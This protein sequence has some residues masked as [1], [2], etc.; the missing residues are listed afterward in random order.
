MKAADATAKVIMALGKNNPELSG[1]G[2]EATRSS[3]VQA[4]TNRLTDVLRAA[5]EEAAYS[6]RLHQY[7]RRAG[8]NG[9]AEATRLGDAR[10]SI[11]RYALDVYDVDFDFLWPRLLLTLDDKDPLALGITSTS[12]AIDFAVLSTFLSA[13]IPLFWLPT[14]FCIST[15]FLPFLAIGISGPLLVWLFHRMAFEAQLAFAEVAKTAIDARRFAV[16]KL[17][18]QD[19]PSTRSAERAL[20]RQIARADNDVRD[21]DLVYTPEPHS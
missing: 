1:T 21:S 15:D 6:L 16:F 10:R 13:T 12:A 7:R 3:K 8:E 5:E 18:R 9:H 14:L 4:C 2:D 17:L 19:V 11:E 20:W